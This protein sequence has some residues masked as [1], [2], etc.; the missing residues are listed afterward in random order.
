MCP[1]AT[2]I[3]PRAALPSARVVIWRSVGELPARS[4]KPSDVLQLKSFGRES[5]C[6]NRASAVADAVAELRG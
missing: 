1:F 2:Y 3:N 6:P 5:I 4:Y